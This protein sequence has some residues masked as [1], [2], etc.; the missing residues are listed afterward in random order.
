MQIIFLFIDGVGLGPAEEQNPFTT[1]QYD[2]FTFMNGNQLFTNDA[3]PVKK[4]KHT[5]IP[6]DANLGVPGLPQSGTGQTA[7]FSGQ[8]ASKVID[9][10]FG[11]WP[12]SKIKYL[13]QEPSIFQ[14][15][16]KQ[17]K[18]CHFINAY[19][20]IFFENKQ[21][22]DRWS[23]TTLMTKNAGLKLNGLEKVKQGQAV[24][25]GLTQEAWRNQLS[26]DVPFISPQNAARR[27]LKQSQKVDLLLHEYYL[28][29]KAGH[30]QEREKAHHY[31]SIYDKFL[32]T[33]INEKPDNTTI[34][35]SS[36][37][38]NIEDLSTKSHTRN[39]VPL[40][41]Y[42]RR[43]KTFGDVTSIMGITP[44]ILKSIEE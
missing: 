28:T 14:R 27:V 24:T 43:A 32:G 13:L 4:Q 1:Y 41:V 36:D 21:K 20:D 22:T 19:P 33:L 44:A 6:V 7:L 15:M 39:R 25:A 29:D 18:Y 8:N 3:V 16:Q 10:H 12:H 31:L 11:P 37:H 30:S 34:V 40:F 23:A 9:R 5:F 17:G 26:L 2:S 35:L 38:G 42:G